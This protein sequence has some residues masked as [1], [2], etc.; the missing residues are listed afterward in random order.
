MEKNLCPMFPLFFYLRPGCCRNLFLDPVAMFGGE[1]PGEFEISTPGN[2]DRNLSRLPDPE[3]IP[4]RPRI[5]DKNDVRRKGKPAHRTS[6]A[7]ARK[8]PRHRGFFFWER[9]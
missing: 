6:H 1:L 3:N 5:A 2:G 7:E 8:R 9:I 4:P